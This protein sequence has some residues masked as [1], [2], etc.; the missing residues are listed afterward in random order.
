MKST[1]GEMERLIDSVAWKDMAEEIG[2]WV[3]EI[4]AQFGNPENTIETYKELA[5]N[6]KSLLRILDLPEMFLEALKQD[7]EEGVDNG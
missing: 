6:K 5:G 7:L 3:D 1:I 4:H 2:V